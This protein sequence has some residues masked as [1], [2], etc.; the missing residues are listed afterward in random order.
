[1][2]PEIKK[3]WVDAL[4]SGSYEKGCGNLRT[5]GPDGKCEYCALGV[6]CD[7]YVKAHQGQREEW[8]GQHTWSVL[9]YA[10]GLRSQIHLGEEM[11]GMRTH[12]GS[13]APQVV[14]WAGLM[15]DDPV[16]AYDW[17]ATA[18]SELNDID[19]LSFNYIA[20]LIDDSL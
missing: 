1:M 3:L 6:L 13:L 19:G 18:I 8:V 14:E 17:Q 2:K 5:V 7:L 9:D 16:V 10:Y 11:W 4:K 20:C 12:T 15:S